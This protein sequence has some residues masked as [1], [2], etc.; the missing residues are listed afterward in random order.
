MKNRLFGFL[1]MLM[2]GVFAPL[3]VALSDSGVQDAAKYFASDTEFFAVI[4]TDD[5][6]ISDLN[7][8]VNRIISKFPAELGLPL[9]P[10]V[11]LRQF[12]NMGLA[13]SPFGSYEGVREFL[14]GYAAIGASNV[15]AAAMSDG[16][17]APQLVF[18][19]EITDRAKAQEALT[20][21]SNDQLGEAKTVGAFEVYTSP[22]GDAMIGLSDTLLIITNVES[23]F[24]VDG[25][26]YNN[27]AFT[28]TVSH[29]PAPSYNILFYVAG[30]VVTDL[31]QIAERELP[32]DQLGQLDMLKGFSGGAVGFAILDGRTLA[33]DVVGELP[34]PYVIPPLSANVAAS[35]PANSSFVVAMSGVEEVIN[36]TLLQLTELAEVMGETDPKAVASQ[37][38]R[39]VGLDFDT[40]VLPLFDG[41]T[42]IFTTVGVDSLLN[43]LRT[44]EIAFA[45]FPLELGIL[46]RPSDMNNA[47]DVS[48]KLVD[49]LKRF[50]AN[51]ENISFEDVQGGTLITVKAEIAPTL[52][53][54]VPFFIGTGDGFFYAGTFSGYSRIF[55]GDVL[56]GTAEY[57]DA[58]TILLPN[59]VQIWYLDDGGVATL[60]AIPAVTI[61]QPIIDDV[62]TNIVNQL[63]NPEATPVPADE[64]RNARLFAQFGAVVQTASDLIAHAT[65]SSAYDGNAS[66]ARMTIT[67]K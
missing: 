31:L 64:A 67:F 47:A 43:V 29:L 18:A 40:N 48:I 11:D 61:L 63:S 26:L 23:A 9:P 13:S 52:T 10:E 17:I 21:L 53:I 4:R 65:I 60:A 58:Q 55:S 37:F 14:G 15:V 41:D 27:A 59:S 51:Q 19:L 38:S 30:K 6:Y 8:I 28:E 12:L 66:V 20:T 35:I 54:D 45:E 16:R 32:A 7:S 62:F 5:G 25:S 36:L 1:F 46:T 33:I 3:A 56:A 2:L 42:V 24:M 39:L 57:M 22:N 50:T 44:G 34:A 49:A